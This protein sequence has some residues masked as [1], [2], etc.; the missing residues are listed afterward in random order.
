M[1]LNYSHLKILKLKIYSS[2]LFLVTLFCAHV[3]WWQ[4]FATSHCYHSHFFSF[5]LNTKFPT[6][7][8]GFFE[9]PPGLTKDLKGPPL[10]KQQNYHA[11]KLCYKHKDVYSKQ[12]NNAHCVMI[13]A[14]SKLAIILS[15]FD[16]FKIIFL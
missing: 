11:R 8:V 13:L 5:F 6:S 14:T 16:A 9:K 2:S 4:N 12:L 1:Q 15:H 10:A 3:T 7:A